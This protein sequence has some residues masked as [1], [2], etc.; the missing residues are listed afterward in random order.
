MGVERHNNRSA[1]RGG[2]RA[3]SQL[4]EPP[5][6]R[7]LY[8]LRFLLFRSLVPSKIL[9]CYTSK[10]FL[11]LPAN[12]PTFHCGIAQRLACLV[13]AQSLFIRFGRA[14]ITID[15]IHADKSRLIEKSVLPTGICRRRAHST[16]RPTVETLGQGPPSRSS[17]D[18]T[19]D[20]HPNCSCTKQRR[21]QRPTALQERACSVAVP[22]LDTT[23]RPSAA[24]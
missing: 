14:W 3:A 11:M 13:D 22:V 15:A 17:L 4:S 21:R 12:L 20:T 2:D 16:R 1:E 5:M 19:L 6:P 24:R 18:L 7:N 9:D 23:D 8:T 10:R